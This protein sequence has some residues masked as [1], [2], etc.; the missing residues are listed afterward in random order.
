VFDGDEL[1]AQDVARKVHLA[2]AARLAEPLDVVVAVN[3]AHGVQRR[4]TPQ[5]VP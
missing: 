1:S 4:A 2:E 3:R 5:L